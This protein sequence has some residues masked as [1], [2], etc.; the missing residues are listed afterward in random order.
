MNVWDNGGCF[1]FLFFRISQ[2]VFNEHFLAWGLKKI[3]ILKKYS[4]LPPRLQGR[5]EQGRLKQ[6][7]R[8]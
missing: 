5:M 6:V 1:L 2:F 3:H 7:L 8:P 4:G